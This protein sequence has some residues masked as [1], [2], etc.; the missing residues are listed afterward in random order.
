MRIRTMTAAD[1][2]LGMRL[3]RQAGWNQTE[4][5]WQRFLAMEPEGCF[6][7][8]VDGRPVGTATACTFETVG[9]IA[10]VLVDKAF[11]GQGI[12]TALVDHALGYLDTR[13]VQ[14]ARLDATPLGR[15]VYERLGFV[16]GYELVRLQ[17]LA[18][19]A[20]RHHQVRPAGSGEFDAILELDREATG[21]DRHKLLAHFLRQ[22]PESAYAFVRGSTLPGYLMFRDGLR[23]TQIGPG[24][25]LDEEAGRALGDAIL[26]R[27]AGQAVFI[28]IPT[29]NTPAIRWADSRGLVVQ[30][31]FLRMYRGKPVAD[32][33][34]QLWAS[35]GPEHG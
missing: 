3:T 10:A 33:P 30:R 13:G 20:A 6:V 21:T 4:G 27:C 18:P 11:R 31:P 8:E 5:D 16:A 15:P 17:G 28:D 7:A 26:A 1:G 23:A 9:W 34:E 12:G 22:Q 32:R 25:A 35:S 29:G 24:V 2:P 19:I 14:S